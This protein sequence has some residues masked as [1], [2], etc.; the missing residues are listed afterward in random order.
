MRRCNTCNDE[1]D[2]SLF[3]T[4]KRGGG[5][6]VNPKCKICCRSSDLKRTRSDAYR[7]MKKAYISSRKEDDR[8]IKSSKESS[9]KYYNS[10]EGRAKSLLKSINR[11]SIKFNEKSDID[12]EFIIDKLNLGKCEVTGI[13]FNYDN[14]FNTSKNP[15]SPSIDRIDSRIGYLK[16]NVRIVIWQYNLMKGE[17]TDDELLSIFGSYF[18]SLKTEG[19]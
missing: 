4:Q 11:R 8:F 3:Y 1:K 7:E 17:L 18:N 14:L 9:R 6:Y 5:L 19:V 12:L 2:D 10:T 15:L 13:D 16:S